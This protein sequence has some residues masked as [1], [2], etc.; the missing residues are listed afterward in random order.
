MKIPFSISIKLLLLILPL[1][2]LPIAFVGY[3]SYQTAL[4]LV[5]RMSQDEQMMLAKGAA[6]K[7]DTIFHSCKLDLE[8]ISQIPFIEDYYQAKKKGYKTEAEMNKKNLIRFFSYLL[9]RSPFY[10]QV[11]FIS[12]DGEEML[13]VKKKGEALTTQ[14]LGDDNFYQEFK[15]S[16][17]HS[18]YLSRI[19]LSPSRKGYV[20][21]FGKSFIQS[22]KTRIGTVVIDLDYD[23]MLNLIKE[24]H[25]GEKGYAFLVDN[26]GRTIAHPEFAPYEIDL[27][28]YPHPHLREFVINMMAGETGWKTYFYKGEKIAA[29]TP[30]PTMG[31]SLAISTPIEE[32]K[33]E[34]QAL[35]KKVF[36]VVLITLVVTAVV[37][38]I[39]SYNL[40]RPVRRLVKAADRI[41]GGDLDQEIP[42]KSSDE[43]GILTSSFNRMMGNLKEIQAELVQ[44]E[45]LISL[46]RLS[47]G[48]AHEIRNP[49]NAMKGAIVYLQRRRPDDPLLEEYTQL[50]LEEIDRLNSFVTDFL[51][52]AK[53]SAPKPM[54]S[55]LNE[56]IQNTLTLFEE[57][58]AIKGIV[59]RKKLDP[60]LPLVY[61]DPHQ[62]EQVLINLVINAMDAMP[63]GGTLELTTQIKVSEKGPIEPFHILLTIQDTGTGIPTEHR[64]QILDPFF[65]TK[66]GGTGLGLPITLGIVESHGGKLTIQSEE[67]KGTVITISLPVDPPFWEKEFDQ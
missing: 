1:V 50:I 3:F 24:I 51:Y 49:L 20:L 60:D 58:L 44:S 23:K 18:F 40:I 32:F 31:W 22:D 65:S 42:V 11:R 19:T 56:L 52:L 35:Q 17:Q 14:P 48:V 66:E 28:N 29:Y 67:R 10:F 37:V 4:G 63:K 53:Q 45:K 47:A 33:K 6:D 43:L 15:K 7:I 25:V 36:Q 26:M 13:S 16:P 27:K 57:P 59:L 46:G 21:Y 30:I 61:I 8:M 9:D 5:S 12:K 41:A 2:S 55:N 38:I 34:V 39:L 62:M 54:A 64:Y